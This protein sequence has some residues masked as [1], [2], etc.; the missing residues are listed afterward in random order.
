MSKS[1]ICQMGMAARSG[2]RRR[3]ELVTAVTPTSMRKRLMIIPA[4]I[5]FADLGLTPV[6]RSDG[7]RRRKNDHEPCEQKRR[8]EQRRLPAISQ[9]RRNR[10]AGTK[11]DKPPADARQRRPQNQLDFDIFASGRIEAAGGCGGA[12]RR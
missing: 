2:K 9:E 4:H 8:H 1:G 5:V 7:C 10:R 11:A 3:A 6:R 12:P